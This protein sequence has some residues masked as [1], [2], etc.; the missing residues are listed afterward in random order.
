MHLLCNFHLHLRRTF[1]LNH[2]STLMRSLFLTGLLS[3]VSL[4]SHSQFIYKIKADSVL[5]TNDS[6][7]AELNLENSTKHLTGGFLYNR[8]NGRTEFRK[9]LVKINDSTYTLGEDT[10]DLSGVAGNYIANQTSLQSSSNFHISGNGIVRGSM[11]IGKSTVARR[12]DILDDRTING[13]TDAVFIANIPTLT[14]SFPTTT[15]LHVVSAGGGATHGNVG[16]LTE[17]NGSGTKNYGIYSTVSN[18]DLGESYAGWFMNNGGHSVLK[19]TQTNSSYN[20]GITFTSP[21]GNWGTGMTTTGDF[22]FNTSA[23]YSGYENLRLSWTTG[24][25]GFGVTSPTARI[26]L[27]DGTANAGEAPLKFTNG[28][29]LTT[30]ENGAVEYNGGNY[31]VT[32]S[33]ARYVLAKTLTATSTLN[34]GS[35]SA[36]TSA[37]LTITV[38]GA[39]DGDAVS[40]GIPIAAQNANTAYTAF[41]SATN[42]VTVRFNNYSSGSVDPASA[43]FRVS[44]LKY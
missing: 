27:R 41:V 12:L 17:A 3:L 11:A 10:L 25:C 19:V 43:T 6:C 31:Y 20:T 24:N 26:H 2:L 40:L 35:T 14:G 22:V 44:V 1:T 21:Y 39:A 16:L 28:T 33:T 18:G 13:A 36:G 34:F 9:L 37:D 4:L 15:A 42:T 7:T 38:S 8:W 29:L 23:F 32:N 5:I 30:P